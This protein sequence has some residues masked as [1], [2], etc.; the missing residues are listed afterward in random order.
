VGARLLE[1]RWT[2]LV[3]AALYAIHPY[4]IFVGHFVRFYQQQQFFCLLTAYFFCRGFVGAQSPRARLLA[5]GSFLA[6]CLS[7]EL[8]MVMV[9]PLAIAYVLF[10]QKTD[11]RSTVALWVVGGCAAV[12]LALDLTIVLTVCQTYLDGISP[13][14]EAT[15]ALHLANPLHFFTL[16]VSYSR[17]HLALSA[18]L[19]ASLPLVI[20]GRN[21]NALALLVILFGGVLAVN[22]LVTLEVLRYLFWLI[23]LWIVLGVYGLRTLVL[24][25][26]AAGRGDPIVQQW[27]APAIGALLM[28]AVFA[29][30]SPWK[31]LGSYDAKIIADSTSGL[32][33]VRSELRQ[34]DAVAATEPNAPASLIE[35]GRIDYDLSVPLMHDFVYRKNGKLID[36]NGGAEVISTLE[37]LQDAITTHDRL[38]VIANRL[39][40]RSRGQD[41][42]WELPAAR[43]EAFL[44]ENFE[45]KHQ[46]FQSAVFLWDAHAGRYR[47]FRQHGTPPL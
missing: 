13:N 17:L 3:A 29:S 41:V 33:Y 18:V 23:P 47:S 36:R 12:I 9:V 14:V 26:V 35:V 44:R 4:A 7:Q 24:A 30:W 31:T 5:V 10:A 8:S 6:A 11:R 34:G 2:G 27:F 20:A 25:A 28:A 43:I 39:K 32:S 38:W 19:F 15:M 42:V 46:S 1:S 37:Q 22:L 16:F 21:R 45:L 40:M